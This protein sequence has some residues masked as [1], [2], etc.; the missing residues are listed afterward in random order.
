MFRVA[1]SEPSTALSL[2][3]LLEIGFHHGSIERGDPF[4]ETR[5]AVP[6]S[7]ISMHPSDNYLF[8]N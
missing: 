1:C 2:H 4:V 3:N 5:L 8:A 6:N 7:R